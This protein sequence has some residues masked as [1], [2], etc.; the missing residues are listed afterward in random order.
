MARY[1]GPVCR[2]CRR[3][4]AKLFLKGERCYT[5]KC[6]FERRAY[7]PGQHGQA[8]KK[9]SEYGDQLREKQKVKRIYS[10]LE[11]QFRKYYAEASRL[12]GITGEN[13]LSLLERRLDNVVY[14][15]GFAT[16]R[17]EA[18]QL[19]RHRHF[20][21]NGKI[22]NIPSELVGEGDV[23]DV[24]AE[25]KEVNKIMGAVEAV[26]RKGV[27]TWLDLDKTQLRG[28][29]TGKPARDEITMPI[30]E[31]LIVELYSK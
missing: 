8:R 19:I 18:R 13:L 11:R 24:R 10:V 20:M 1:I 16:T 15:L 5:D 7:P 30:R 12:K 9:R 14:R 17:T 26:D 2:L 29:V 4:D 22:C 31:Q 6:A 23:I 21:I 3:E 28:R 25:S 27:P